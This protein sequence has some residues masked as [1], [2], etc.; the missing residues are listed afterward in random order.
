MLLA[1]CEDKASGSSWL[2]AA[3]VPTKAHHACAF[4][5]GATWS[6]IWKHKHAVAYLFFQGNPNIDSSKRGFSCQQHR[7]PLQAQ[8]GL[9]SSLTQPQQPYGSTGSPEQA[10]GDPAPPDRAAGKLPENS[11]SA[12]ELRLLCP[13]VRSARWSS[14][15]TGGEATWMECLVPW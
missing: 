11:S 4:F 10:T 14:K 6:G 8:S 3:E 15:N 7:L 13:P 9:L 2:I 12:A 1:L 5:K